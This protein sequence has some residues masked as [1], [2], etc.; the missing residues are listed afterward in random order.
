MLGKGSLNLIT[1]PIL[2]SD[3]FHVIGLNQV[4]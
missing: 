1:V 3:A 2:P 4:F